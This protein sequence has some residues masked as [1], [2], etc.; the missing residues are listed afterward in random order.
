[1]KT[2]SNK[3][4]TKKWW[5]WLIVLF[6]AWGIIGA[7]MGFGDA[8][9]TGQTQ[10][11]EQIQEPIQEAETDDSEKDTAAKEGNGESPEVKFG[12]LLSVNVNSDNVVVVKVKI[13]SSYSN[14][15]TIDQNYYNVVDLIRN[16]GFD[17]YAEIQYWA[18]ADMS[19]GSEQ[20]VI[21][22][23][24][25]GDLIATISGAENFADN[26]LGDYLTD[27]WVHQSLR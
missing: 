18:V 15:A 13:S 8:T 26:T 14:Q 25:A 22:F 19:D 6:V 3:P 11:S 2:P 1:M 21:S 5:F 9:E 10:P 16:Q 4:I 23:T 17:Q 24:V 7:A 12:D 20:K 27:L